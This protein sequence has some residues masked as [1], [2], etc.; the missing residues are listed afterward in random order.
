MPSHLMVGAVTGSAAHGSTVLWL[1]AIDTMFPKST[2]KL[3]II[4]TGL[5]GDVILPFSMIQIPLLAVHEKSPLIGLTAYVYQS[6]DT[7]IPSFTSLII[8]SRHMSPGFTVRLCGAT[9]G[10]GPVERPI[11]EPGL[12]AFPED[13]LPYLN[14]L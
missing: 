13:S 7:R 11:G 12:H 14:A 3:W 10:I 1:S 8:S 2:G 4:R 9:A 6:L 5:A